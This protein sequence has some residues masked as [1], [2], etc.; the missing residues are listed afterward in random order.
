MTLPFLAPFAGTRVLVTGHTG[1]KGSWLSLWLA[2]RGAVVAGYALEAPTDPSNFVVSG[3]EEVLSE[4]HI[5]DI[6]DR[7]RL[8]AVIAGF[9]PEVI[10]HLAAET[11][12]LDGYASPVEAFSVNVMGT[13]T[14]LDV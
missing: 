1:F 6:R 13:V 12:V 2:D 8:A 7:D 14:L 10:L 4:H 9:R 11:V 3:V 5:G